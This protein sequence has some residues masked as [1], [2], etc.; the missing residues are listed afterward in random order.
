MENSID[1]TDKGYWFLYWFLSNE[2]TRLETLNYTIRIRS[3]LT[4]ILY[5]DLYFYSTYAA[6]YVYK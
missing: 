4:F 2:G 5:F 1:M 6:H 3:T